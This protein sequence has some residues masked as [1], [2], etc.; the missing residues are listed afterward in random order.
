MA[1][2]KRFNSYG[3][4]DDDDFMVAADDYY[5]DVDEDLGASAA[6]QDAQKDPEA[7]SYQCLPQNDF[8]AHLRSTVKDLSLS[9]KVK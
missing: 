1:D 6:E 3:T 9:L 2:V 5:D 8:V 7:F 4:E